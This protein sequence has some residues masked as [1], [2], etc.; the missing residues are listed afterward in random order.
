MILSFRL[1]S[2]NVILALAFL[3]V[4]ISSASAIKC[5]DE[6]TTNTVLTADLSC[7]CSD[8]EYG[9]PLIVKGPAML[10]LKWHKISC[11]RLQCLDI[12][13][14]GATVKNGFIDGGI[15]AQGALIKNVFVTRS[16]DFGLRLSDNCTLRNVTTNN[17]YEYGINIEGNNNR[18]Y[19]VTVKDNSETGIFVTGNNN[20]F[21]NV[22]VKDNGIYGI[23]V[24]G[25]SNQ[26]TNSFIGRHN[27]YGGI[28]FTGSN[29]RFISNIVQHNGS[30]CMFTSNGEGIVI[31]KN[32]FR[33][34]NSGV[35]LA[36]VQNSFIADNIFDATSESSIIVS[37]RDN[38]VTGIIISGNKITN[39]GADGIE[40]NSARKTVV[41]N[42][43]IVN[44][45]GNGIVLDSLSTR[46]TIQANTIRKCG[47]A[48][49]RIR[50]ADGNNVTD[51]RI[52]LCRTGIH[53]GL[54]SN[55][56]RMIKNRA[57]NC[58]LFDLNDLS[59][60]CGSNVWKGNT[61]KGNIACTQKN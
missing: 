38:N 35:R 34:C 12:I 40:L 29:N 2:T 61:G 43:I 3:A 27:A 33:R 17:N 49:L 51:N 24:D 11:H 39:S 19:N 20:K 13:G 30:D 4:A 16:L 18:L 14:I 56:N 44:S 15:H 55:R 22:T 45:A 6:I 32:T 42:N 9:C 48:G 41:D 10:D 36:D 1:T 60:N 54:G 5:G 31:K 58:T 57:S 28:I 52:S 21:Y 23:L 59:A 8:S 26:V 50:G 37:R 47:L 46:C 25:N 53:A 7:E